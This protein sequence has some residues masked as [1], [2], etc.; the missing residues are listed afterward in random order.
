MTI[1]QLESNL[2]AIT[3]TIAFLENQNN[4]DENLLEELKKERNKL[5]KDINII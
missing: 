1:N 2:Q 4:F 3:Q 5:L